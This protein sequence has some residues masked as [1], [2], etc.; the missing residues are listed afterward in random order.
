MQPLERFGR[1]DLIPRA[2][3]RL[4]HTARRR[5]VLD[6]ALRAPPRDAIGHTRVAGAVGKSSNRVVPAKRK[7]GGVAVAHRPA[8]RARGKLEQRAGPGA[9]D[10]RGR[11]DIGRVCIGGAV[12]RSTISEDQSQKLTLRRERRTPCARRVF[13]CGSRREPRHGP[14]GCQAKPVNFA[15]DG[16][17]ADADLGGDLAAAQTCRDAGSELFDP[18]WGPSCDGHN[19]LVAPRPV[20]GRRGGEDRAQRLRATGLIA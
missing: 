8:A 16:V 12:R 4:L 11:G 2:S 7:S 13:A 3:A 20:L 10:G 5:A 6:H 14:T 9:F 18:L 17:A 1:R 19:G 15:D